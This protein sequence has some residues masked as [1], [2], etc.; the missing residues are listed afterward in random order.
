MLLA[1]SDNN[2]HYVNEAKNVNK[3]SPIGY[4]QFGMPVVIWKENLAADQ[5]LLAA[6]F[7]PSISLQ[8]EDG[9]IQKLLTAY[10]S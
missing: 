1:S 7:Q 2:K 8:S 6:F 9:K 5:M 10:D 4:S 3:D